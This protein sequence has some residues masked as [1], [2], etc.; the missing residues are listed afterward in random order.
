MTHTRGSLDWRSQG[1]V[2]RMSLQVLCKSQSRI[3][4]S[5][6]ILAMNSASRM[7][8]RRGEDAKTQ[9]DRS[10]MASLSLLLP[11]CLDLHLLISFCNFQHH[12]DPAA[13]H[14][15]ALPL[16]HC[17][18][19]AQPQ[20]NLIDLV[21]VALRGMLYLVFPCLLPLVTTYTPWLSSVSP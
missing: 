20:N 21:L 14:V 18:A 13:D 5:T 19:T 9:F 3:Y 17:A 1:L 12:D 2:L 11:P 10:S 15:R 4:W 16:N 8:G 7:R 6:R